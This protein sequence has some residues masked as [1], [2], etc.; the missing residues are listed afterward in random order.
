[1]RRTYLAALL[2]L[3]HTAAGSS[4]GTRHVE[5]T[6]RDRFGNVWRAEKKIEQ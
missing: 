4:A 1:M 3:F 5:V 6:A 2:A